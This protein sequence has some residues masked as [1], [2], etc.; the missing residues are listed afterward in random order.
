MLEAFDGGPGHREC[1]ENTVLNRLDGLAAYAFIIIFVIAVEVG[2]GGAFQ[3]RI[4]GDGQEVGEDFFADTFRKSLA[5]GFVFLAV[6]FDAMAEDL[7]EENTR[8]P[9]GE[10]GGSDKRLGDR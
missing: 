6:S 1:L 3:S 7:V 2:S 8:S 5:F 10:D 4:E 9:S